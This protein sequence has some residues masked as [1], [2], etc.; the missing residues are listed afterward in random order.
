MRPDLLL[1]VA[2][3]ALR[4]N[5]MRSL[6]TALGVVIGVA[7]VITIVSIGAGARAEVEEQVNRL[8]HNVMLIFRAASSSAASV[9]AAARSTP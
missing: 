4:R 3:R 2:L 6:L 7:A 5:M 1:L 9:P 8:G